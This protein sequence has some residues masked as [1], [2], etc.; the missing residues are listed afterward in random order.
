MRRLA[1]SL[2]LILAAWLVPGEAGAQQQRIGPVQSPILTIDS[3]RL[4]SD[5][6][7]G[8]QTVAEFEARGAELAAENRR[9]EDELEAEEQAL[10]EQR[11]TMEAGEFRVLADAF[12]EKVQ[13]TRR[14]Q[15]AKTR[16]LSQD[17]EKRRNVFLNAAAPVLEGLMREAGAVVIMDKRA[18]FLSS[19]AIDITDIA[20]ERLN[21]VLGDGTEPLE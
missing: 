20:T 6:D 2:A 17:F 7:F 3:D 9:I 1:A 12:D 5:S 4:F 18:L 11:A 14:T 19:N 21:A 16:S 15:D 8:Q 13:S 10:T